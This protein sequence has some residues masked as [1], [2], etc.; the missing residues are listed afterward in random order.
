V[1]SRFTTVIAL[2]KFPLYYLFY[3]FELFGNIPHHLPSAPMKILNGVQ[4]EHR[5]SG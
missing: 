1:P 2:M 3:F 5:L 4:E